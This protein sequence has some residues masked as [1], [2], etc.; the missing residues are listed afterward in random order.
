[1]T[2]ADLPGLARQM[3]HGS[4]R[5]LMAVAFDYRRLWR[6]ALAIVFW[7]LRLKEH[8][9]V[10]RDEADTMMPYAIRLKY[11]TP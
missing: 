1:M 10:P 3:P 6:G 2:R 11:A 4:R 7:R 5:Q 8:C 9:A